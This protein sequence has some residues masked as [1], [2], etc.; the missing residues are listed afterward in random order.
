MSRTILSLFYCRI[1]EGRQNA[2]A[3]FVEATI[4]ITAFFSLWR[5]STSTSGLD[6]A[7]RTI[8][9]GDDDKGILP[10][11][12]SKNDTGESLSVNNLKTYL[13]L[14]LLDRIKSESNW[15]L[16]AAV[17]L[18][19]ES[20]IKAVCKFAL[21]VTSNDVI[22]DQNPDSKG[23]MI[24]GRPESTKNY[25]VP[26]MWTKNTF[27]VEHVAPQDRADSGWDVD[28]YVD[29][30]VHKIGNLTL[31]PPKINQSV[32]NKPWKTKWF[33]YRHLAEKNSSK[34]DELQKLAEA[35]DIHPQESTLDLLKKTPVND[36]MAP[37]I[38]VDIDG[39]WDNELVQKRTKRLCKILWERLYAWLE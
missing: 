1:L 21:F 22:P 8:L 5:S 34:L 6:D 19:Y 13:K 25:L 28:L 33:Y 26:E 24:Q 37:I 10:L 9:R 20:N 3:D 30:N 2:T 16:S 32:G 4:A 14:L 11:S 23:L 7:Y 38:E 12:W 15:Q 35:H 27:D 36:H 18:N 39:K 17:N 31:L 29:R